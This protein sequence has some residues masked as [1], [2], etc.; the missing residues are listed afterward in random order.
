MAQFQIFADEIASPQAGGGFLR[1]SPGVMRVS[2][3]RIVSV[4]RGVRS[5]VSR[6]SSQS[7]RLKAITPALIDCHTHLIFAGDRSQEWGE[8]LAGKSY[9][10]IAGEGGGIA[11]TVSQTRKASPAT[12]KDLA[13]KRLKTMLNFGVGTVE[14]KSG[15]G[16]DLDS[17]LKILKL[18]KDLKKICP[19]TLMATFMGAHA[20]PQEFKNEHDYVNHLMDEVLPRIKGLANFQDVFCEKGYFSAKESIRL[21]RAGTKYGLKPKVHAHEFGRTGGVKAAVET[22]AVSAD[23]LMVT[24]AEDLKLLKRAH[25]IPVIL[26]GTSFF[27]GAKKFA[28]AKAMKA[29]G[30]RIAIASD[31]NPGTNPSLN[32]PLAGTLAAI[33]QG[34]DLQTVLTG[35]THHAALA[36][37]LKDRGCL[38]KGYRADFIEVDGSQFEEIYYSYGSPRIR[39]VYLGGKKVA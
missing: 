10:Q 19:Q 9:Q 30:L 15:Y 38:Q 14:I 33:H 31:F 11:K 34:L 3:D 8:R 39:S 35:Q 27:L 37:G 4:A 23:H 12:L 25:V 22:H 16:L 5:D 6:L 2:G 20:I 13:L 28:N 7:I 18:I 17:E 24:N 36:L 21:L 32:L 26:P 1:L 29:M